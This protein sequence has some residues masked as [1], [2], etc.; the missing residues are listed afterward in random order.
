VG[1]PSFVLTLSIAAALLP[2]GR[3]VEQTAQGS[4]PAIAIARSFDGLGAGMTPE[5]GT[6][7]P[8]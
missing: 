3:S 4:R 8:A 5:P 2:D 7:N 6:N 1:A